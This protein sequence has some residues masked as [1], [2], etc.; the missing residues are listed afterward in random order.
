MLQ[1]SLL[2]SFWCTSIKYFMIQVGD[3]TSNQ[4][5]NLNTALKNDQANRAGG[6]EAPTLHNKYFLLILSFSNSIFSVFNLLVYIRW[7][8]WGKSLPY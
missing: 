3:V 5:A 8:I 4:A 6:R 1:D 2:L 7:Q